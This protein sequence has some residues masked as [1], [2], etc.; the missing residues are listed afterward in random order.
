[1]CS[2]ERPMLF[3]E[4]PP[5]TCTAAA[6]LHITYSSQS[7][8]ICSH[9]LPLSP[10]PCSDHIGFSSIC[11]SYLALN[12]SFHVN[13]MSHGLYIMW[14]KET[15]WNLELYVWSFTALLVKLL[16]KSKIRN[17][18]KWHTLD[19]W[20]LSYFFCFV[21]MHKNMLK[22]SIYFFYN[23]T[24]INSTIWHASKLY[25][26]TAWHR[27][28]LKILLILLLYSVYRCLK[29]VTNNDLLLNL[30]TIFFLQ[31]N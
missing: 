5:Y 8:L 4:V 1:M 19:S 17:E 13:R 26:L 12:V 18:M 22:A 16:L 25:R 31:F 10:W 2:Q 24:G 28:R 29:S 6:P 30:S 27:L 15:G 14:K 7:K 11:S 21:L 9:G 23:S 20:N 3:P